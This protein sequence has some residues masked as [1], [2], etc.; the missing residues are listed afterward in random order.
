MSLDEPP[1][2]THRCADCELLLD[3]PG[4]PRVWVGE[5]PGSPSSSAQVLVTIWNDGR[6][7]SVA[8][9]KDK[10]ATWGIPIQL[11]RAP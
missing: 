8:W 6:N 5:D 4:M 3:P 10:W 2:D 1:Y 9:R 11:D 7:V